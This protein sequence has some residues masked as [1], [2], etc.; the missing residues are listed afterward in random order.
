[1]PDL[2]VEID[3]EVEAA[4]VYFSKGFTEKMYS[5]G[6]DINVDI[7]SQDQILIVEFLDF[8]KLNYT[9]AEL[10]SLT[11]APTKVIEAVLEAQIALS[12]SLLLRNA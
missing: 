4:A 9:A 12:N 6:D 8:Q 5:F 10:Q 11:E 3:P 2:R 7:T 1:M